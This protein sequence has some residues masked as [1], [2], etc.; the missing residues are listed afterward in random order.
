MTK[1]DAVDYLEQVL[2][3]WNSWQEHHHKLVRAL[4]VL[5]EAIRNEQ[6]GTQDTR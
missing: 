6:I 5:L 3:N 2:D 1:Q 4:E